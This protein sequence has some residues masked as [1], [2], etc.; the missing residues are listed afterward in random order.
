M[1]TSFQAQ[2][3]HMNIHLNETMGPN[4]EV[5]STRGEKVVSRIVTTSIFYL[6]SRCMADSVR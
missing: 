1:S 6:D 3:L 4:F 2:G 5:V